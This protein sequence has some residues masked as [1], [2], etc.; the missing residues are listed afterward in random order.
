MLLALAITCAAI[1]A[2]SVACTAAAFTML[3]RANAYH[4]DALLL[5]A[6][7]HDAAHR[8]LPTRRA[9]RNFAKPTRGTHARLTHA[10]AA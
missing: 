6:A 4:A 8:K 3:A 1:A 5:L 2:L 7:R 9:A 10:K